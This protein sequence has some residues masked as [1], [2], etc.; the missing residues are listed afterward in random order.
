MLFLSVLTFWRRRSLPSPHEGGKN[1]STQWTEGKVDPTAG[2]DVSKRKQKYLAPT[3]I[4]CPEVLLFYLCAFSVLVYLDCRGLFLCLLLYNTTQICAPG[5]IFLYSLVRCLYFIRTCFFVVNI[6]H[7]V[8]CLY[9]Q[10]TTQTSMPRRDSNPQ[11]QQAIGRRP[12]P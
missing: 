11:S 7:F 9:L 10:H 8:F 3:R 2:Q 5:E 6:L 4:V 12:S 1:T